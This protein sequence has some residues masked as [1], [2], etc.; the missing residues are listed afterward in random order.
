ME[1]PIIFNDRYQ[2]IKKIGEGGLAQV[3]QAQDMALER[4]VAVKV[5]R[6]EYVRDSG[7]L[8]NFH[9]EAQN[10]AKLSDSYI[11]AVYDFGQHQG[12]PY[13]V[14]EWIAGSDLRTEINNLGK[15]PIDLSVTYTIQICSAVGVAHRAGI[16]HGDLKPGNILITPAKQAKVTDFGLARALGESAMDEGEVVWG[17]PAYFA[18]EQASGSRVLPATDVYAIGIILY[19]MITGRVPFVGVDDQD[20][21]R[22]Q[23]YEAHISVDRLDPTIPEP[24]ARIVDAAMAKN[25]NERFL[26]ADQLREALI[27]YRQGAL[28]AANANVSRS[29]SSPSPGYRHGYPTAPPPPPPPASSEGF[30]SASQAANRRKSSRLDIIMLVLAVLAIIAV[31]GLIPLAVAVYRAYVPQ[32][33]N[34]LPESLQPLAT[35]QVRVPDLVGLEEDIARRTLQDLGIELVIEGQEPHPTWPAFTVVSQSV[36][37]GSGVDLGSSIAAVLSQGPSLIELPNVVGENFDQANQQ[38]AQFDLVIQKYEDWSV[39][40]PGQVVSQDPP[41]GSLIANR[42]L[43]TL[44]VSNGSRTPIGAN[45]GGQIVAEAYEI[46]RLQF[47]PGEFISLT[48]F[49]RAI[50]RP[51]EDYHLFVHLT[52]LEGGIVSQV[53]SPPQDGSIPTTQW[54]LNEIVVD[55]YQLSIPDSTAPGEYQI[56]IGFYNPDSNAR[57]PILEAGRGEQDNLGALILRTIQIIP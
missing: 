41:P 34:N 15:I 2:L 14:M 17:T 46:P 11:V 36:P 44:V 3:Y 30:M 25:V 12:H 28:G 55:P 19:E 40:P 23:L 21:A 29:A 27:M 10:A 42:T 37:A 39:E 7:F 47:K 52:T 33:S 13:I 57:L 48:F 49:W 26:T 22:K 5:L 9:R 45:L 6:A 38:L 51:T 43:V 8:V 1:L 54:G 35:G 53:D 16:V 31:M 20:V 4:M 32:P 50:T 56:R 18:P 24:L